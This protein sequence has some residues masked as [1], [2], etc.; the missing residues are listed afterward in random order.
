M[1][2]TDALDII[3]NPS[4]P[5]AERLRAALSIGLEPRNSCDA[6]RHASTELDMLRCLRLADEPGC[7]EAEREALIER[8]DFLLSIPF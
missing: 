7:P 8:A 6:L 3:S 4:V 2:L 5:C 1:Q